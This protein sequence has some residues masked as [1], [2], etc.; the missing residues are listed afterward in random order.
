MKFVFND[1]LLEKIT[2]NNKQLLIAFA[3]IADILL[4][5]NWFVHVKKCGLAE[6][7]VLCCFDY[8][9]YAYALTHNIPCFLYPCS[10][11]KI[12]KNYTKHAFKVIDYLCN[13][14][15]VDIIY[16]E[17]DVIILRNFIDY[18]Y[19]VLKDTNFVT[20]YMTNYC[21]SGNGVMCGK[22]DG[23]VLYYNKD[24]IKQIKKK[25]FLFSYI[26]SKKAS[27]KLLKNCLPLD[28]N[29]FA[30]N[31]MQ[32]ITPL[33]SKTYLIHFNFTKSE[34]F[35]L[36]NKSL[37]DIISKRNNVKIALIKQHGLW[38]LPEKK[39]ILSNE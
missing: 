17:T 8:F 14:Y 27:S 4:A 9:S 10:K 23:I 28:V 19:H 33:N 26:P 18:L 2:K 24:V 25:A 32:K 35:M 36:S 1:A 5:H 38:L 6:K 15:N 22:D 12:Q 13:R 11:K 30:N 34:K 21:L 39:E 20:C 31:F 3:D 29:L 7:A 16:S 37:E